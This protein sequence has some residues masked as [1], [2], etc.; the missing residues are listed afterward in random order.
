MDQSQQLERAQLFERLASAQ[1]HVVSAEL[2]IARQRRLIARLLRDGHGTTQAEKLLLE[3]ERSQEL[4]V[5]SCEQLRLL[6]QSGP[7]FW[8]DG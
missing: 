7:K 8:L 1:E 4:L 3:L 5:S 2:Q 6:V